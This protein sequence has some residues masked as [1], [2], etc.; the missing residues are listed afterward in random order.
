MTLHVGSPKSGT[1][2][3]Q[4]TLWNNKD[5]LSEAGVLLPGRRKREHDVLAFAVRGDRRARPTARRLLEEIRDWPGPVLVSSEW[6]CLPSDRQ[7]GR[8]LAQ[9]GEVDV[10]VVFTARRFAASVPAAWSQALKSG[11]AAELEDFIR[12]MDYGDAQW[13]WR[14]I[15]P[16]VALQGW[17]RHLPAER[18]HVVTV[19]RPGA[20]RE[21]LWHRFA[22]ACRVPGAEAFPGDGVK[23][24]E[25]LTAEGAR[26][27]QLLGPELRSALQV[28]DVKQ[29][30]ARWWIRQYF[31]R[32]L[33]L[34]HPGHPIGLAGPEL[35]LLRERSERTVTHLRDA[36]YDVVGELA[37]LLDVTVD[38]RA[39]RPRDVD[40]AALLG[41][42]TTVI[43]QMLARLATEHE[44]VKGQ[45][46]RARRQRRQLR[47]AAAGTGPAPAGQRARE[48]ARPERWTEPGGGR[49]PRW[50]RGTRRR[51][52]PVKRRVLHGADALGRRLGGRHPR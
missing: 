29:P 2:Y 22:A 44:A 1:T 41:I 16:A 9:L 19:P 3:L 51:L 42:T 28:D 35:E 25:S 26:L 27:L 21:E 50:L 5:R 39:V 11:H 17:R 14:T 24:N 49:T 12:D 18:I 30:F 36:G 37:D 32:D 45:R 15:D 48:R 10:D 6:L 38:E 34:P 52:G 40:D 13:S 8:F 7:L 43:P 31:S 4:T 46:A 47:R 20:P 33:V 23:S